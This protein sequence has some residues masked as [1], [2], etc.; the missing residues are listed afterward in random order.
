MVNYTESYKNIRII[1]GLALPENEKK[2]YERGGGG[3]GG[4]GGA[5]TKWTILSSNF[6]ELVM[7]ITNMV[8][9]IKGIKVLG[10][11][12]IIIIES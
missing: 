6:V 11:I 2:L 12:A 4:G 8:S 9:S 10:G 5:E 7:C 3:G 1:E